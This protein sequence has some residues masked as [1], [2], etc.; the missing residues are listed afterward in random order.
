MNAETATIRVSRETRDLLA[1]QARERG[2][3]ISAMLADMARQVRRDAIF[4]AERTAVLQDA[5]SADVKTEDEDW[6]E[7]LTD[8]TD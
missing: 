7:T 8:G 1:E 2:V 6:E 3:S 4:R 5:A